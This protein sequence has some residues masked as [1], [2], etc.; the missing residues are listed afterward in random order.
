MLVLRLN[1]AGMPQAWLSLEMAAKHYCQNKVLFELGERSTTLHGG[2]DMSGQQS[3]LKLASIIACDGRISGE[4]GKISLCNRFLF[5]RDNNTCLYCGERFKTSQLTRDHIVP[6]SQGG[7]DVWT[8]VATSCARCNHHK[9]ART[10]EQAGMELLA[11]PF[12]PNLYEHF[13]LMN[14]RI[15]ADQMDFLRNHFSNKRQWT[16]A[17]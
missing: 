15:L 4:M 2:W 10:P 9:G 5:R 14:H 6:R 1:K 16:L 7:R 17:A 11:V 8:N 13:Y 3:T 12:R